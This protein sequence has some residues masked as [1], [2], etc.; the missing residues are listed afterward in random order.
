MNIDFLDA[1]SKRERPECSH[2]AKEIIYHP[3]KNNPKT[4]NLAI[5]I[6]SV[7][8]PAFI[9]RNIVILCILYPVSCIMYH[10]SFIQYPVS[11]I[12]YP[13]SC[14][15]YPVSSTLYHVSSTLYHVS[16]ILYRVSCI[17]YPFILCILYHVSCIM[18]PVQKG[19]ILPFRKSCWPNTL[20]SQQKRH[21]F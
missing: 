14:I 16:C 6:K 19:L 17:L 20:I 18:Y 9:L 7:F 15:M 12:P 10:V 11:G 8:K 3:A 5:Q 4:A 2:A 21:A 13:V 1:F